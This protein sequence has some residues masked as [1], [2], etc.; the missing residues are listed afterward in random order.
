MCPSRSAIDMV[1]L[2][3]F[4]LENGI[5]ADSDTKAPPRGRQTVEAHPLI[6]K[7]LLA[8][9]CLACIG[10]LVAGCAQVVPAPERLREA[11]DVVEIGRF[12]QR[13]ALS[14]LPEYWKPYIILP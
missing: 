13:V 14:P 9:K 6:P 5:L 2:P 10:A 11:G 8:A 4:S 7:S 1:Q 3:V 12:S